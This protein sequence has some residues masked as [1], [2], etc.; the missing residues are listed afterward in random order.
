M[1]EPMKLRHAYA[2]VALEFEDA[3]ACDLY[4]QALDSQETVEVLGLDDLEGD[5]KLM[6]VV[7]FRYRAPGANKNDISKRLESA[8]KASGVS[9]AMPH[10]PA[11]YAF[12]IQPD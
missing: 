4:L 11:A 6:L 1:A 8:A 3:V 5:G 12:S 2:L 7:A 10:E 9:P